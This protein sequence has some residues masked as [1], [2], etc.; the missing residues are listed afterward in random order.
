MCEALGV[1]LCGSFAWLPRSQG[2]HAKSDAALGPIDCG[3]FECSDRTY[4]ASRVWRDVLTKGFSCRLQL[5]GRL[6]RAYAPRAEL[7]RLRPPK[8]AEARAIISDNSVGCRFEAQGRSRLC[9]ADFTYLCTSERRRYIAI[10]LVIISRQI[11]GWPMS[12]SMIAQFYCGDHA[13]MKSVFPS[14]VTER[15]SRSTY[16]PC[17]EAKAGVLNHIE[18]FYNPKRRHSI[19]GCRSPNAIEESDGDSLTYNPQTRGRPI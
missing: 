4:G 16:R 19:I 18:R 7:R 15:V 2:E 10:V 1:S 12:A 5:V 3:S 8:S 13:A 9:I 17:K 11:V 14:L 6:M